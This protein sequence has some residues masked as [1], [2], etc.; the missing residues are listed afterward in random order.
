MPF[1]P[2]APFALTFRSRWGG[3]PQSGQQLFLFYFNMLDGKWKAAGSVSER[4]MAAFSEVLFRQHLVENCIPE[5]SKC[6]FV[7]ACRNM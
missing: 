6:F 4:L 5:C 3:C 1:D 2:N 7:V